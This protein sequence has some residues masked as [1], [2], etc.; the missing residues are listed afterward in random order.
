MNKNL[1]R[2]IFNKRR[3]QL[4]VVA[5]NAS[6]QGKAAKGEGSL[7][8]GVF[9]GDG[10]GG[11]SLSVNGK[12]RPLA[13][14]VFGA[15][16]MVSFVAGPAMGQIVA[17][18]NAPG[19]Q[20]PTVVQSAN[21]VTQVN[22]QTPSAAGV[23]RNT[24]SQF[25]VTAN[26]AILNNSRGNVQ[27]QT[28]GWVQGNPW[29]AG[30][31][32]RVILN[33][34]NSANPSQLRGYVEVA[35]Q[36]AEVVIANPAGVAIDGGGFINASR[37]VLTTGT[38]MLND[39]SL[40][41]YMVQR[42]VVSINGRG[43]DTSLSDYTA[44]LARAAQINGG[45]W[46]QELKV[47][48]GAN[49]I[50]A[51]HGVTG[52][53]AG[54]G[55]APAYA[56]DVA[57][58]GGM[59]AGKITL[60]GTEAGLGVRNAGVLAATAGNLVL[61]SN[62][63][64]SNS[65]NI[66]SA[67][68]GSQMSIAVT[69]DMANSG[70]VYAGGDSQ[71]QAQGNIANSGVIAAQGNAKVQATGAA[72]R[73]DAT[74][75]SV[76]A[77]GLN[78]DN[79]LA[80]SGKLSV[81]AGDTIAVHGTAVAGGDSSLAAGQL[82]LAGAQVSGGN[83][84]LGASV[85]D[86]DASHAQV[87]A[88][89]RLQLDAAHTVRSDAAQ[90][91]G[92]QLGV[93]AYG[94]SNVGGQ[95][96][97]LG[98]SDLA[99]RLPGALDN[100]RGVIAT[101]SQAL[102]LQAAGLSNQDGQIQHAG[103][104]AL[105]ID[106][107]QINLQRGSIL[108]NGAMALTGEHIDH[109]D[110]RTV[111]G[112]LSI[113]A[114]TL[115]NRG[116]S[117]AQSGQ[118]ATGVQVRGGLDNR[119]GAL[120]SNGALSVQAGNVQ[121]QKGRIVSG[122]DVALSTG[123]L[124]NTEATLAAGR[125]LRLDSGD[126][127]NTRGQIQAPAG[128]AALT[129]AKL[130]NT[131]G[132]VFA[133]GN[134]ATRAS[135][136]LNS[137]N[138]YAAGSQALQVS[139][140]VSNSGVIAALGDNRIDASRIDSAT[141][142]L[143]GAGIR[144][145]GSLAG[146]GQ[147][148]LTATQA[149][150][151]HGQNL[152][153]GKTSM[154]ASAIDL[155]GSQ[156]GGAAISLNAS[157]G[158]V[159]TDNA[160]V[161]TTG[162]LSVTAA[163]SGQALSNVRGTL[164]AGQLD[165]KTGSLDNRG[166]T[167]IQTGTGD[168]VLTGST[169]DNTGG[170]I[171]VN[172]AK[173]ALTAEQVNNRDGS[174]EHAGTGS[175]HLE[176]TRFD[177]ER[178]KVTGNGLVD[179]Q[180]ET[181]DH[182]HA[183]TTGQQVTVQAGQL[184]NS[185]GTL[186]QTGAGQMRVDVAQT[187]DNTRGNIAGNG[188]VQ[189]Q[190]S[191][192]DNSK[193]RI[194][195]A[196]SADITSKGALTNMDGV[197]AATADL[198]V[199]GV[200]IDNT[201]GVLQADNLHLDAATLLNQQ[202]TVS[203]GSDLTA[204]LSADLS[205]TGLLYAGRNQQLTVGGVLNNSGS[206]ASVG[207]TN[208]SA[209]KVTSSG[210]LGAGV[211]ADGSL[212]VAG[213]LTINTDGI[214]QA[215]GQNL[216]AGSAA[217]TG[218][219]VDL[220]GS[221]TGAAN[222]AIMAL[223][224]DVITSTAVI[225]ASN[226][227]AITA[228]ANNAQSLV[229]SQGQLVG[230][231]LQLNVAN[232]N[233]ASGDIVQTGT[234]DTVITTGKLDNTAGRIAVNSANLALNATVLT[235]VNGKLE[236]AGAGVLAINAGQFNNQY[237]KIT[238]NGKLDITAAAFD[239]R[240]ATTV[241]NQL[242]VNA[243]SLNN[244]AGSLAQTGTGLMSLNAA[245]SLDNTGGK[246]E[247]NGDALV[248][249]NTL[250]NNTG[251]IV[252]AQD[253]TLNVD[254][255]DN[256]EGIVAAGRNLALSG[257]DIDNTK[258]QLQAVAGNATLT[259]ANLNNAAGNVFAGGNLST[260]L[261]TLNNTGSLYAAGNQTLNAS[262][263]I[264]NTGVIAAQ[265]N[266]SITAKTLDS[267]ATSLLG[268]GMQADGKL[269]TSGDLAIS[270]ARALH[271]H[272][273]V[274]AAGNANLT[275]ATLD[276]SGSQASA[277]NIG[278]TA[279]QGDV[280]TNKAVV[281]T[282]GTLNVTTGA[283]LHNTD[284]TLQAGQLDLHVANLDNGKGTLLQTGTGNTIIQTGN[285]DNT[286]G[287]IAVNSNK[288]TLDATTLTNRDGKI[289]HAGTGIL[290]VQAGVL[291]NSKGRITSA[292]SADIVSKGVLNNTDGVIAATADLHV[293]G[294]ALDN[295]RGVL[296]ADNL[297]LDT[298][299][300]LNQQGTVSA[301]TDLTAKISGDL[302]NAGL[303]YAG[304]NQ[305]WT[306]GG[307]LNNSGSIAS[308]NNTHITAGKV[309]SSGLLG[310]GIKADGSLGTAGD[311]TINAD[312]V[313]QAS[314]QNLAA[315]NAV[316]TGVNVDL[317]G[318]QTG[319]ANI[320]ITANT[321]DVLTNK[322]VISA[323]NV[324]AITANANN[325]QSLVNSQGQL[326]AGQLQ[327]NVANLNNASGDIVQTGTGDT[328]ITTGKLD[329]TAGRIAV[330][331]ANLALNATVLTNVNGK[332][333][334]AGAGVLAINAGQFNN[335]SG[336]I[337][338]NGKLDITAAA[339]DHRNA[340]TVANQ[341]TINAGSL[342]NRAGSLAQTGTGLMTVSATGQLDNTGGK[343]EGNGDALVKAQ[344]LLNNTG[345]I[346]AA[347]D[348]GLTVGSLDNTEGTV[349]AGRH[350]QLS[351]GDIDNTKGQLQAVTGNATL[352]V[353]NLNNIAGN[354][355]AGANLNAILASLN[356]TGSLY[357]AGN[358]TLNASGAIVN[359][360]VIA[361]QGNTS[362]TAKTLDSGATSLLGA[363]MQAD[364][365][366]GTS[367]DLMV[368][369]TQ[370]LAAHG[371]ILA[372]GSANL[373]GTSIDIGG[374]QTSAANIG[375]TAT[376]GDVSTNKAVVTTPGTL[377]IT[378]N[379]TLH[380]T[381]GTLQAGQLDLHVAN[382]DNARGT[383]LQTGTGDTNIVT[384]NLDNTAGRI[385]VN[386]ANLNI[387]A[388][389]VTNKEGKIEHAGTG[390]LNLQAG[391]LD[392]SK[393]RITS[394]A[395]SDIV[396]KGV[397]NNTDGVIAAIA[398][399]H[400]GGVALD[401]TRG[402]LQ[403][404]NLHLDAATLLNQQG[405]VSAAT[406]LTAKISGDLNNAGLLYA[407]RNQQLTVGGLLNNSGSIA[408]VNNAHITAGK[409]TSS[410]LLG[411]GI[412]ADGSLG[413]AGDLTINADGVLQASGQN[414]AA[415]NAVLTG[416]NVDLSGS[417][418]GAANIAIT[419]NTDDV[420]T[421]KAVISASNVLAITANANNAQSLVNSQGQL[422]AGQLQLNVAN[423][424]NASGEIVQTGTGDTVITTG[425]L[426]NTAGRIAAN[427]A[428]LALNA[429]VLTN[430]NGKL[431]HAG[432]GV[433][434]INAGQFNNQFGK[435]TGN[436]KVDITA[437]TL[438][439]RNATTVANQLIIN[440]GSL[441]NRS[442]SLAQTGT[443]L[444]SLNAAG[445]LDNTGG[446]IEGNG[447]AL[448]KATTLLN[449]TG[450]IV[451]AQDA[452]LNVSS[453]DN[454]EGTVAAGRHLQ[455]SG[456]DID[457]TKGQLQAVTG[458]ATLNVANLN[459][460]AGNVFAGA[461]LNA[462]LAS[463]NNTGSLYAA[464]NQT[465][466]ASGAIV[467]TGVIA[468]QGNTSITAKT[469]DSGATSLLGAGM[470]ADGKL[471]TSGDL[472]VSATRDLAA[473]GQIL[474]AGSAN[475]TGTSIDIGG[476][477]TSAANIG[478]TA[479]QGDVSTNKAVVTTPGTL[480]ITSNATLHNTE[481]TLQAGQLDLYVGNLDNAK[482]TILQTG[483]GDTNIVTGNLD[484][485]A[486]RI[487]VNSA[488][489]NIDAVSVTN[490][491]GK[492]EHAGTG[493]LNVQAGVLD[494]SKGRITS[495]ASADIVS[496]GVLNNT[497]GVMA[498]TAD[499]HVGGVN[500]DNTR[501]VLQADNLRLDAAT[502]LNQQ[503]TVSAATDLTAKISGDLNNAGLLY[504]GRNQ[505]LTVGGLLSNTGSIASV[506]NTHITAGKVTSSGLLGAGVKA[507]GSLGMAGDLTINA[508]GVLQASGQN[509]AAGNVV[510]TGVNVDLSGS[511]TG[512]ANIAIT[513]NTG[514][515]VTNKAVISASNVL[516]ITANA[517]NAQSLVN[518]QGQLVAGQ[519]Q[520]NVAN[521]NNASGEIVQ[522]GTGDTVITTGK[523]DNTAGRI[524]ANSANLALNATVLTNVNGKLEHAG[525]GVLA[526]NAG[527][528]NNQFGKITGNGKVDITAATLD[529]R[530]ATTVANQL[531]VN[532]GSLDNR[533]GSLAQ[534][535]TGLMTVSATGQLD[536]TG[537]KIEGNG[538]ALVKAQVLLNNTGRIVAAQ[539]AGLTVG[540]LDNTDGTVAAGRHL[541]LSGGDIDN[542][543]GQLQAVAGNA[544]LNVANLNNTAGN[545]FAGANLSATLASLNNTGSMYAA[546]N[547]TLTASGAIVNTGVIAAQG[548]N[549]ITAKTLDSSASS[550]LGAGMRADGK[551]GTAGDLTISTT[552]TLAAHGQN[553]A[554]GNAKLTGGTLDIGGSQTS[555]ANI[556]L[557]ATQGDVMTSKAIV[558]T[559]GT[560]NVTTNATLHNTEGSLQAG[561]LD[562]HVGNLDNAKGTVLQ[563]GAGDTV[564]RTG[565]L[566]NTGGRIAV[567]SSNL[568]L[569]ANAITNAAGK[570]EHAGAG[571]LAITTPAFNGAG[572]TITGNGLVDIVAGT[573]NHSMATTSAQQLRITADAMSNQGGKLQ[574]T[575]ALTV[576]VAQEL[577]NRSGVI[578][579]N[580]V[581][582]MTTGSLEN[583]KGN[584]SAQGDVTISS[585]GA[586]NNKEGTIVGKENV[587]VHALALDNTQGVAQ[588]A[589]GALGVTA[590]S[591][592]NAAGELSAA[593]DL[594]VAVTGDMLNSGL[595]YA[596]AQQSLDVAGSLVNTGS[597]AALGNTSVKAG[598]LSGNGLLAAG[599]T[600]NGALAQVGDLTVRSTGV[601]QAG[602]KNL[603][604]GT[605]A[606]S[607]ASLDLAG[608]QTSG[609]NITLNAGSGNITT[610]KAVLAT[611]GL[612][613]ITASAQNSQALLN[614]GG[615]LSAG[616]LDVKVANLNNAGG[617]IIQ[618]GSGDS[619]IN[620][621]G[622]GQL[623][624]TAG[625][626]AVN[627]R[628][629]QLTAGT[630][631][632]VDGKIEHAGSGTLGI[633]VAN[634]YGQRGQITGNGALDVRA[635]YI[636]HRNASAMAQQLSVTTAILDN[637]QG[638]LLQLGK[639]NTSLTASASLDNAGG[640]IESNGGLALQTA[641]LRNQSGRVLSG[642]VL[643]V[644]TSAK[645]DNSGGTLAGATGLALTAG[646]VTNTRGTLQAVT[647]DARLQVKDLDN[648]GGSV[649]AGEQLVTQAANVSNS[650]SMY[651]ASQV[652]NATGLVS[653]SGTIASLANTS[654]TAASLDS[655]AGGLLAA[656]MQADGK[657][658]GTGSLLV[659][660]AQ[661]L[662]A[663]G[664]NLAAGNMSMT[665]SGVDL[666]GSVN[667]AANI[668]LTA[669]Q[670]NVSTAG[671]SIGTVGTLNVS[672]Q[673]G[674]G[675]TWDNSRGDIVA[676]QLVVQTANLNN[677]KG[678]IVQSGSGDTAIVMRA[679]N[680]ALDNT[681][682]RIAVN[683][684][685]LTL[686]AAMLSNAGG[687]IE[688][689]GLGQLAIDTGALNG[690]G[691]QI[692][693]NGSL[694][695]TAGSIDFRKASTQAG[696]L[697]ID[698]GS[699]DNRQGELV[700][701]G[702]GASNIRIAQVLDN[703]GG[704]I[705]SNGNTTVSAQV[706]NNQGGTVQAAG[707]ATLDLS[708][709]TS[710]NN[711]NGGKI[712][713]GGAA[714]LQAGSM[715]NR[716]GNLTTGGS[717]ALTLNQALDN[718][719]G[720]VAANGN[721]GI[722]AAS[723]DNTGG[724]LASVTGDLRAT[725]G[726]LRNDSGQIQA[727]A[728][729][730]L[731]S[732][733]L[734]NT[735]AS[736]YASAGSIVG[737]N[738]SIDT[739]GQGL[740]NVQGTIVATQVLNL[741]TGELNNHGGLL[742]AGNAIVINTHGQ[743]L[744][745]TDAAAYAASHAGSNGGISS[746]GTLTLATGAWN[747]A[748]GFLGAAG[749]VGGS[750]G[751]INNLGGKIVSSGG[752][753]LSIGGLANQGGQVQVV[754]NLGLQAGAGT[755]DNTSGLIR[756]GAAVT[757]GAG[758]IVNQATQGA[759]KGI[760][761][762]DVNLSAGTIN[763]SQGGLRAG[764]N[765]SINSN[766]SVNNTSGLISANNT[767]SVKD[768][769]ASRG[770]SISNDGGTIIGGELTAIKAAGL[771]GR[772]NVMSRG[773]L[774]LDL[775]GNYIVEAGAQVIANR[776]ASLSVGGSLV[777]AGKV[778]AGQI[779]ALNAYSLDN[780]SS[781]D[782]NAGTTRV[783]VA[784]IL[785][786]RGVIDGVNTQV[787]AGTLNNTGSGRIYGTALSIGAGTL[788]ND[789]EGGVAATIASRG[790]LDI[791][792]TTINN[793]EHALIFSSGD[794]AIGG[795]LDGNRYAAGAVA[796]LTNASATIQA[797]GNLALRAGEITLLNNHFAVEFS[798][799][800]QTEYITEY[801]TQDGARY[802][803]NAPGIKTI[804]ESNGNRRLVSP[805]PAA[806][807]YDFRKYTITRTTSTSTVT[808]TDPAVISAGG[809]LTV[810]A[811]KIRNENSRFVAG[812]VL[813]VKG[814]IEENISTGNQT[815]ITETGSVTEYEY[816]DMARP[817]N[818]VNWEVG[819]YTR[820]YGNTR[821]IKGSDT[822][823]S[824]GAPSNS[825][826]ARANVSSAGA[827]SGAG[828]ANVS[829]WLNTVGNT[830]GSV[831]GVA[832]SSGQGAASV[833]AASGPGDSQLG[834]VGGTGGVAS[835]AGQ[836]VS[837][838]D[839]GSADI[840]MSSILRSNVGTGTNVASA[841]VASGS[842][843][844]QGSDRAGQAGQAGS[845][846]AVAAAGVDAAVG[847]GTASGIG[848]PSQLAFQSQGGPNSVNGA[849]GLH[850]SD[851][852]GNAGQAGAIGAVA[853]PNAM[854]NA[855]T[856][857]VASTGSLRVDAQGGPAGVQGASGPGG[858]DRTGSAGQAG[859]VGR[860]AGSNVAVA[861]APALG[862]VDTAG[863]AVGAV[864]GPAGVA[865]A[866]AINGSDRTGN[867]G[868][869]VLPGA[870]AGSALSK[871]DGA[872]GATQAA[873]GTG[874]QAAIGTAA[875]AA[876]KVA[877]GPGAGQ[878][879]SP[880]IRQVALANPGGKAEVV[881]TG[882]KPLQLP[883]ASL[884]K[885]SPS[886]S[887]KYLVETDPRFAEYRTWTGS[888]YMSSK[889][890]L[891][892]AV[893]QKRLGDGF[894]EQQLVREQVADLTG[895]RFTG[896]YSNDEEQFRGLMDAGVSYAQQHGLR[897]G[898]ALT[899]EQMAAL[900]SDIVWLVEREVT[901]ADG[902]TQK[903]LVPQVYVRLRADDIDGTGALLAGKNV[904]INI[905]G[906][907]TNSGTIAG[908][909]VV[910]LNA[911][912]V[913]NL[914]GRIDGD[915]VAVAARNDLNNISGTISANSTLQAS[916]GRDIN[917]ATGT[918]D[919]GHVIDRVAGLYVSGGASGS[920]NMIVSAGRD[921]SITGAIVSNTEPGGA[922]SLSAG[923]DL[924][925]GSV[926]AKATNAV[927]SDF[928][929]ELVSDV[930]SDKVALMAGNDIN[931]RASGVVAETQLLASAGRDI[932]LVTTIVSDSSVNLRDRKTIS[933]SST[934][935][936]KV[937]GLY[938]TGTGEGNTLIAQAGRDMT[939]TAGVIA[940]AGVNGQTSLIAG[941]N[942]TLNTVTVASTHDEVRNA[943]NYRKESKT[944]EVGSQIIGAGNVNLQAGN[945]LLARAADVQAGGALGLVAGHD[946]SLV[947]G[948][949]TD[950]LD[951]ASKVKKS[952]TFSSKT[953]TTRDLVQ[954]GTAL[955][956]SLTGNTV[957]IVAGHDLKVAGSSVLAHEAANLLAKN[958]ISI[959]SV[960]LDGK[961]IHSKEVKKSGTFGLSKSLTS[962]ADDGRT[963]TQA[964][965]AI[966]GGS[967]T[968]VGGRDVAIKG[969][970]VVA[971]GN[972][973]LTA[974]RNLSIVSAEND[975]DTTSSSFSKKSGF[976]GSINQPAFGTVKTTSDGK[977][978]GVAQV[979]SQ[980][981]S[982]GGNVSL[983][984]GETY[985]Q[986]ASEVL[987]TGAG[988][989]G[990]L[991]GD[992]S[993][994]G[995][996]VLIKEAYNSNT[997]EQHTTFSKVALGGTVNVPIVDAVKSIGSLAQAAEQT[998]DS[999]MQA[1000]AAVTLASKAKDLAGLASEGLTDKGIKISVSLGSS[1001]SESEMHQSSSTVVGSAVNAAGNVSIIATGAGADSDLTVA[1002]SKIAAGGNLTLFADDKIN[1003]LAAQNTATQTSKNSSSGSSIGIGYTIGGAQNGFSLDI[1004]ANKARGKAD[1005]TDNYY[1006]NTYVTAGKTATIVSGGDTTLQGAILAAD[1007]VKAA[1008]GGNLNIISLQDT[1009]TYAS[1010]SS[1011]AGFNMSLCIPPACYGASTVGG[1012]IS[1013]SKAK[1014]DFASVTEQSG[1015][1016]A[1017]DGGFQINVAGNTD[1018]QAGVI[1019][1020]SGKAIVDGKNSLITGTLTTSEL[1021][1022]KDE[1023][1024]ASGFSLSGSLE[1025]KVG[1026]QNTA[1027]TPEKIA[1028][1029]NSKSGS[1030]GSAGFGSV[1031]GSQG[1032]TTTSGISGGAILI[1033][1034]AQKQ[1035]AL[1036]GKTTAEMLAGLNRD[1037]SSEKDSS[1038]ALKKGWDGKNLDQEV[1039]AQVAI[1040]E[1041]FSKA[1042]TAEIGKFANGKLDEADKL[1043]KAA[1044]DVPDGAQRE[1045]MYK[1046]AAEIEHNWSEGG[1047]SRVL[1048]NALAGALGGGLGGAVA[1049]AGG[1050]SVSGLLYHAN[1051]PES[1052]KALSYEQQARVQKLATDAGFNEFTSKEDWEALRLLTNLRFDPE[1053]QNLPQ[1054]EV[1055]RRIGNYLSLLGAS[1056]QQI[1057]EVTANF[1058]NAGLSVV[1059]T[1060]RTPNVE[1061]RLMGNT[1062]APMGDAE[1063]QYAQVGQKPGPFLGTEII[1064]QGT[1065]GVG[1066]VLITIGNYVESN[1067]VAK[1068]TLETLDFAS[1069]PIIYGVKKIPAV[1070]N[1071]TGQVTEVVSGYFG[1072]GFEEAGYNDEA[1073]KKGTIGATGIVGLGFEGFAGTLK[1074]LGGIG[1075]IFK[1076]G[1077]ILS[1078][1079][1080]NIDIPPAKDVLTEIEKVESIGKIGGNTEQA[1081]KSGRTLLEEGRLSEVWKFHPTTRGTVIEDLLSKTEYKEWYNIGQ[1082]NSGYF[1083]LID[1084]QLGKNVV[1085][1086]KTIDTTGKG[1087]AG[1088]MMKEIE[1089]LGDRAIKVDGVP[1090][1091]KILDIRVQPGGM[1092]AAKFL[1093]DHG[1094]E[1095]GITVIIKE[1096]K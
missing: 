856:G 488:N 543:K 197:M 851:R 652:L 802:S 566:D 599:L 530:N 364:G 1048:A 59:Y 31:S 137:G 114:A 384:G 139:G 762:R 32:A 907:L 1061:V 853:G 1027:S 417:Q 226:V 158:H 1024:S 279:T 1017:G 754:G 385:A 772:G 431:E 60:V 302:N 443:G 87:T 383:I 833:G 148:Q 313:L 376:Q 636:D 584:I 501:G 768:E 145:D 778:Q 238:G 621:A 187:L 432:A 729:V 896:D 269:G 61:Q 819:H 330:N 734:G 234:G 527:Q 632:N 869:A 134:L 959:E 391:V 358:Q 951:V 902:S 912:N 62:G 249:A 962:Q 506:N 1028:A 1053:S 165:I 971:D 346:V 629:L 847:E 948:V 990:G 630:L 1042:A 845:I 252:A 684:A 933:D 403:A 251:R 9:E 289:E 50:D 229:N 820:S 442:G 662:R 334:H 166:G 822:P 818:A 394:A 303:L 590:A 985:T 143:L 146:S 879:R 347:Q 516:A 680:G 90:L 848:D 426:D 1026:T 113:N 43:L 142:S 81:S 795:S 1020:S 167:V 697:T 601:L 617:S 534:T 270:T 725:T 57:Q 436:G 732:T 873:V 612:L 991:P 293:G 153:A 387:D 274:L 499:L 838:V 667:S 1091:N 393:G 133:G 544:T 836:T 850:G 362:I 202:G 180:A 6:S 370:D 72:A 352:N 978:T 973:D 440:A 1065:Q 144:A 103:T 515:V 875:G 17:D 268:A 525:A 112:Q 336:K 350:L 524:A 783:N 1023:H 121:N 1076:K 29:L 1089:K 1021:Q 765:L 46:A 704:L 995:K 1087:W 631:T 12:L 589:R 119:G 600:T 947:N 924:S 246:I 1068:Y 858:S 711:D 89:D 493:T 1067:M 719:D 890:Q 280:I 195:S 1005:G 305:Q 386:S 509:L 240:N 159:V 809:N 773:D 424:N 82:D 1074:K 646:D 1015:I 206:I 744:D 842:G 998:K 411:A 450:R 541:Q 152:A 657:L 1059:N 844:L 949:A 577:D 66:Q 1022:N 239:H 779:L 984:A 1073:V 154:H 425:K 1082:S 128:D 400:V 207:N 435:I 221:Q 832:A 353:A 375:L 749:Q 961:E 681:D 38:P 764:N 460:I 192:L 290:S 870:V 748:A 18:P 217:L 522:T 564:I 27:T 953:T 248:K 474:A 452:T 94:L 459:N 825:V 876:G 363:G 607:G 14:A 430:I 730:V 120:E 211:K 170:R 579:A 750:S 542:T 642:G 603:A 880:L 475:L 22:I 92:Q 521:L 670:G 98:N 329:N 108:S 548:N 451:T 1036:T 867:A 454:T 388:V 1062:D 220:S 176:A 496:K 790:S 827:S 420:V 536:N 710:L 885:I 283:A 15:L 549:S 1096:F 1034:D 799:P 210:L 918:L 401:N 30:G 1078:A 73:I 482:G 463:L 470:Q 44:I 322:A 908:R 102:R 669:T 118:G 338:G 814:A 915:A 694:K 135:E 829:V 545:V 1025:A 554:A 458:N 855:G 445:S 441:D 957:D 47:V 659:T 909:D 96:M 3:G 455:L 250:L 903:A 1032:S 996:N 816:L 1045:E 104:G 125:T 106:A 263:A 285:L 1044:A 782:I 389:S 295:T 1093:I 862:G 841:G 479:T 614:Q 738:V 123:A 837:A 653:N 913:N 807:N 490:K 423:L 671:A 812:Q 746:G 964:G 5:E 766:G 323:S 101:N 691:G 258:G 871:V 412:K 107:A 834:N 633:S 75:G 297:R 622:A 298:A 826:G 421:N 235:N 975:K 42:G 583:A 227:L 196:A 1057:A 550:L 28:G 786:N 1011:S 150:A 839:G 794:M 494:N 129:V 83:V 800:V 797:M 56:L 620:L 886:T 1012:S 1054:N 132:S 168:T 88:R 11:L 945:D 395:S 784:T 987:A 941:N 1071:L 931:I 815:L 693:A 687:R 703:Q 427:S 893:T 183:V 824:G 1001:K 655:G 33:E 771:S 1072:S 331:S 25:D 185:D 1018:L 365:K 874:T 164:S 1009:S 675:Q 487:A 110:A 888:D 510:L 591:L 1055:N 929:K 981:A 223:A 514:D 877:A 774:S 970:T 535:G 556:G 966:S 34:V 309:T 188:S 616:Q 793:R 1041:A 967:V 568:I 507:D 988:A 752:L 999:R 1038:G 649:L 173:L 757:L 982:L 808:E 571:T 1050:S 8:N 792:A 48:T 200:N 892:P 1085:S 760:E 980:I 419:A 781:G 801:E 63:W 715:S 804:L 161:T 672:A 486:G 266:T 105:E 288:L 304:R 717:L 116:G 594:T 344:V 592:V 1039:Q 582:Q 709:G 326:V 619:A 889:M 724:K 663:A 186:Q 345:R 291:D 243:G 777:N 467:N 751:Y 606:L 51:A 934:V 597:I 696:Q 71:V 325:A 1007:T 942:L 688:H 230:G 503:G 803:A 405:T 438:D 214:L 714:T 641:E 418:T 84:S 392:N 306:V 320:A 255:L 4:M 404:D 55:P 504:A 314:G 52:P 668:A 553:L 664:Q 561:Q 643:D 517:N 683:S 1049:S 35:G 770:L 341:L 791:G 1086:L 367:G 943:D 546:G 578:A 660:T 177:D 587:Q 974:L 149:I 41:G 769:G 626:I 500:I 21:G 740:N 940:N 640:R 742:Q 1019:A 835:V 316:L 456:G 1058:A 551:L 191:V 976:I 956:T 7:T 315:G 572:G 608:S 244:R 805:Y 739:A 938:V 19:R 276:I 91:T 85:G 109:R 927:G 562:L 354:V 656:G 761:G 160:L 645:L 960:G 575:T 58:L 864:A 718:K 97:Q 410:G 327:L 359:T 339:F 789:V 610:A 489:L 574:S 887:A 1081:L 379:A 190:A 763:N 296:Q 679:P 538:D 498:A 368:S 780:T 954:T 1002:G 333:E 228:N 919:G 736:G 372:A 529:H 399:L 881:R 756:G 257:A 946:I 1080:S 557:T 398:D 449:S 409:V 854:L 65:G 396:S 163:G 654:I 317:S 236:H 846:S 911:E 823:S 788:N 665:G 560:L 68:S 273:Q 437:A 26:G 1037:V 466:N 935:V 457:N 1031:S 930:Q 155:S 480:N 484:N 743:A 866:K 265:G 1051:I 1063:H 580:G 559:T 872:A 552:Q 373:T 576:Q 209:N 689:A 623:D 602:G 901:L 397:L 921:V 76:L 721:L 130:N 609:S 618:T 337:T 117:L 537:G 686:G 70:T 569:A 468:A 648:N 701:L 224:G 863:L 69:G 741:Q 429:T 806:R 254:R 968:M 24:Y 140:A 216:A 932:N 997:S 54:V 639:G 1095:N 585:Q 860:V 695:I 260:T 637:R 485:T 528:F 182:R 926:V 174:I 284:G 193:G 505:Q 708:A 495:A 201:R 213:D 705:A 308:V 712:A 831:A 952:G 37:V 469:L 272:G 922:T 635:T 895:H 1092:D 698:S 349:A 93:N 830:A 381:E 415:G 565:N 950:S 555:A 1040:T 936:D 625:R 299:T 775:S 332:L 916:A 939:L 613:S 300:L 453:L 733:S 586:L 570:I 483:T 810:D 925:I 157:A 595:L 658:A 218:A 171:A 723:I 45:I 604:A 402:V 735:L 247:G 624:N 448:V 115:D 573:F 1:Y 713:A 1069:G 294:T 849:A 36:R 674:N 138:L 464:G 986:T 237:G 175:L 10:G 233:N 311:L 678:S 755:I 126:I 651:G 593:T 813:K 519:L 532:A 958:D 361:A 1008:I 1070:E 1004:A 1077:K 307:L 900:T 611:A 413:M 491:E 492:I 720:L 883:N 433:L 502:L 533:A 868:V 899:P 122:T 328:V 264:V 605:V 242:T 378:S 706:I 992:I 540:S 212:G 861:G 382:L 232:L 374:S 2:I 821:T 434:A 716:G 628:N 199:E 169:L 969:S 673:A 99:I 80:T 840:H 753:E 49:Q 644:T 497:D 111:A 422:V 86:L 891:D 446:K 241:A 796:S 181:I 189:V 371:Q 461:N 558:A 1084:F 156:T 843:G 271:A 685:N 301:A 198:H 920:G 390:T 1047:S 993:I 377:N 340:T 447:D 1030:S 64:L 179:I 360:G 348:A 351:G 878:A 798:A 634:L 205:N 231:Q 319:A 650:G 707:S 287:R 1060:P 965:S 67:G 627:S 184:D 471:G 745:N 127:D 476:S 194:T 776:N 222:I 162:V 811:Y 124:D 759:D 1016:K 1006:T 292:A 275:G 79:T 1035:E 259:V 465:L 356:N 151:A 414:L 204:R 380:N 321:G 178:G 857:A 563:T 994:V 281:T 1079:E 937:A 700:Q 366:L 508:D 767:V 261:D 1052:L 539:D 972:I 428:N 1029:A 615:Q 77:A 1013:Q 547:Q 977:S 406:D 74:A 416:V 884:F 728:D 100:T 518:S 20:R 898:V 865:G 78:L 1094:A 989:S 324:L 462:I 355:F 702:Q 882:A 1033:S 1083:P 787:D 682:G 852:A 407:G 208:I 520:L 481:G 647:G 53:V 983:R 955:G 408:S 731:Q 828:A 40:D 310:A 727:G 136:V 1003:L 131:A 342:D 215:N 513:A 677:S 95:I 737:R 666:A 897:P 1064:D 905:T 278:L 596:G 39:G 225:S 910:L 567:N 661:Q 282:P 894:Y 1014:G 511:Q 923:R 16:G 277:A 676:G 1046:Q 979:G 722:Q 318:S 692:T 638:E 747:N 472:T 141:G 147:L 726:Q 1090:A 335:Q 588:A 699:L 1043:K 914:G 512:A 906:D 219:N 477:Q 963:V 267:G 758:A 13:L 473:H 312:G 1088:T 1056:P 253:A 23:S 444:M 262:G 581:L 904:D 357:A 859:S 817:A 439:H 286:A 478:L 245:G 917:I 256:T 172:S 523:L 343:I 690:Q 1010:K 203:A 1066:G 598:S 369:A 1075:G 1000:L 928:A 944:G 526:I 531:T 785:S